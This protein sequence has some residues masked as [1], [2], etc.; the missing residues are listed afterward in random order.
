MIT[1]NDNINN[2]QGRV[3]RPGGEGVL[4]KEIERCR[5]KAL[6]SLHI[7]SCPSTSYYTTI[8]MLQTRSSLQLLNMQQYHK[9]KIES[10]R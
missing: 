9:T 3:Y 7:I 8:L 6:I 2:C 4:R 1:N 5:P 10:R